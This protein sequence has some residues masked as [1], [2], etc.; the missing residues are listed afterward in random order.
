M[1]EQ[2]EYM[3]IGCQKLTNGAAEVIVTTAVGPR[4]LRY[5]LAGGENIL[6]ELPDVE[7]HVVAAAKGVSD[8]Y[9]VGR[10]D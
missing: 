7:V 9:R 4:I 1:I 10:G 6:A 5:A 3:G 8:A 2:A